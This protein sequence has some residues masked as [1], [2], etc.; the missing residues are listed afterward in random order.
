MD[1]T[2]GIITGGWQEHFINK[3]IDSI[4]NQNIETSKYEIIIVGSCNVNTNNTTII[5]FNERIKP[6]WTPKKKN[7]ITE[8]SKLENIVYLHDYICFEP[9]WY[10]NFI[11]F[12]ED[13]DVCMN[14][15]RTM[16]NHRFR[17]WSLW[18]P[19][20]PIDYNDYTKLKTMYVS[21]SYFCSKKQFMLK[22]PLNEELV[23]GQ[24]EDLDWS[25]RIRD[26]WNYKCNPKSKVKLLKHKDDPHGFYNCIVED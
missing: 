4:E 6:M 3:I 5:P 23:W 13:W 11:N 8:N 22:Y 9:N 26:F 25:V 12:G 15:I 10:S 21:G 17:D 14:S 2:F 1:W 19:P 20:S 16:D 7:I 18:Y 24:G